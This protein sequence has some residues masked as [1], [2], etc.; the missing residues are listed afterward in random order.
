MTSGKS[1]KLSVHQSPHGWNESDDNQTY[2]TGLWGKLNELIYVG[3]IGYIVRVPSHHYELEN[4]A[5]RKKSL[6][7]PRCS[8]ATLTFIVLQKQ[9]E[10]RPDS[11]VGKVVAVGSVVM[12]AVEDVRLPEAFLLLP[13]EPRGWQTWEGTSTSRRLNPRRRAWRPQGG[14]ISARC[15][16]SQRPQCKASASQQVAGLWTARLSWISFYPTPLLLRLPV[17]LHKALPLSQRSPTYLA[18]GTG[19]M[20]DKFSTDRGGEVWFGDD[21]SSEKLKVLS[22]SVMSNS[23]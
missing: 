5:Q 14:Q 16:P 11:K 3:S 18:P 13:T 4:G 10:M 7:T 15:V 8:N 21:A 20:E 1:L 23:L 17:A 6:K 22:H 19:F 2:V 9:M 12:I